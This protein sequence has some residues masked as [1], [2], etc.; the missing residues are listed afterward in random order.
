[1]YVRRGAAFFL[2]LI[3]SRRIT[4]IL[5]LSLALFLSAGDLLRVPVSLLAGAFSF[6]LLVNLSCCLVFHRRRFSLF[7]FVFHFSFLFLAAGVAVD[8]FGGWRAVFGLVEGEREEAEKA[9]LPSLSRPQELSRF[10]QGKS[11]VVEEVTVEGAEREGEAKVAIFSRHERW[12]AG[13]VV[14]GVPL[15]R[16]FVQVSLEKTGYFLL[17]KVVEKDRNE[18]IRL[19]LDTTGN[20]KEG[21]SYTARLALGADGRSFAVSYFPEKERIMVAGKEGRRGEGI[22]MAPGTTVHWQ[23][24]VPWALVKVR[25]NPGWPLFAGGMLVGCGALFLWLLGLGGRR[26][27]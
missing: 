26:G 4:I 25:F 19:G 2:R 10:W 27:A 1:M 21:Y 9:F 17:L 7:L 8:S 11:L 14:T 15:S 13:R 5:M 20:K 12:L 3:S 24:V 23:G 18:E 22:E 6:L 16:D